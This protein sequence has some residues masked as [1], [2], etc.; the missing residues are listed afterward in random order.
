VAREDPVKR[1]SIS[2]SGASEKPAAQALAHH[3]LARG[4]EIQH[5]L[6]AL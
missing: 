6:K 2:A 4:R 3:R 1:R 5:H